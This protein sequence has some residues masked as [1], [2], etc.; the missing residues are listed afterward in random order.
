MRR[1][2]ASFGAQV[3]HALG[4]STKIS[5][6][7]PK[8]YVVIVK[9]EGGDLRYSDKRELDNYIKEVKVGRSRR[10]QVGS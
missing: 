2:E 3:L 9:R 10:S 8:G 6:D 5:Y 1:D 4:V 7:G